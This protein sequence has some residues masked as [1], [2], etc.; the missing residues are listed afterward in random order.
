MVLQWVPVMS[1]ASDI[2]STTF[3]ALHPNTPITE[4][5][6]TF[7]TATLQEGRK[8]FG[9][10]V[11]DDDCHLVGILSMYDILLYVQP[12]HIQIWGEMRDIDVSGIIKNSCK[13]NESILVKDIMTTDIT[14]VGSDSHL[15]V[16][17]EIMNK[18]HIRRLPVIENEKVV[19]IVYISDLFYHLLDKMT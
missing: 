9:M 18:K 8:I 15:F 11:I 2:M 7:K 4:A 12:K 1:T 14:T 6:K 16:I 17:L 3:H 19:G 10:M 5:I 13:K